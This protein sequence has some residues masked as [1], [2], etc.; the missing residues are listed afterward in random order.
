MVDVSVQ[1]SKSLVAK[2]ATNFSFSSSRIRSD[3]K[4]QSLQRFEVQL[5]MLTFVDK[6]LPSYDPV[7]LQ[8]FHFDFAQFSDEFRIDSDVSAIFELQKRFIEFFSVEI[9]DLLDV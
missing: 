4:Q 5:T 3:V 8:P 6:L 1:R 2:V 7:S 9:G